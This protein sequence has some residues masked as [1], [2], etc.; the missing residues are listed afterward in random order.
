MKYTAINIGP[1]LKTF[2]LA[3]RPREIWSASYLFSY[4]MKGIINALPQ[5]NNIISPATIDEIAA[6]P[7]GNERYQGVGLYPD[8][9]FV[10][11]EIEYATIQ[12]AIN[13]FANTLHLDNNYFNVMLTSG[14]FNGEA[15]AIKNLNIK[16]DAME[17]FNIASPQTA[18]EKVRNL[19]M[20]TYGSPLFVDALG[21][22]EFPVD[23]LGEISAVW[24]KDDDKWGAFKGAIR[25]KD[26]KIAEK[27]YDRLPQKK[28]K[29]YHKYVCIVQADGD[30]M[31]AVVTNSKLP[32]G[33]V[34]DI[35][36]ELLKFGKKASTAIRD[37]GGM[38][39]YAGGDDLLFIAPVVGKNNK[40]ILWLLDY[41]N[42]ES[43][44]EVKDLIKPMHLRFEVGDNK[45]QEIVPSLSFGVSISY[46]K[47]PLYEA[48]ETAVNL[49]FKKA[50]HIAHKN[51]IAL[52]LRKHSGGTFGMELSGNNK[53]L[54]VAF[55]NMIEAS[56]AD[57]SVISAVAH[58]IRGNEGLLRLWEDAPSEK[59]VMRNKNFFLNYMEHEPDKKNKNASDK[60][61]DCAL[62]L[63]NNLY[64]QPDMKA[65]KLTKTLYG[66]LRIAKFINGEEVRDE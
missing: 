3:S 48:H 47:Y 36:T 53:N 30:N 66:M 12:T 1:I 50:K 64:Q 15:D 46:Y 42:D 35:S 60:Y 40:S 8:R 14:D 37:F 45:G 20:N 54:K 28:L 18:T 52:E 27:A 65:E 59:K 31:G 19:I 7:D 24:F 34:K 9:L 17:L 51:A 5:K 16:L 44:K 61:K 4:L 58:K 13:D 26:P 39:I 49:L 33:K 32:E 22:K 43:F 57:E 11:G 23:S 55:N 21:K 6:T 56:A 62:N 29:S 25:N 10:K 38:P 63:L 2:G 41:I